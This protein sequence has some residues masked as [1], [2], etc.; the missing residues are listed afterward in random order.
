[1]DH[2]YK[3][4]IAFQ[5]KSNDYLDDPTHSLAQQL[6]QEVQ[7][8]EDEAQ[9]GKNPRTLEERVKS[10]IRILEEVGNDKIMSHNHADELADMCEEFIQDLRKLR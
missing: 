5:R 1:M 10:V 4:I 7:R 2:L 3:E 9:V 8:L 6:K